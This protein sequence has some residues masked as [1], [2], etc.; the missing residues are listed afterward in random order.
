MISIYVSDS[1]AFS[2]EECLFGSAASHGFWRGFGF[3]GFCG[4]WHVLARLPLSQLLVFAAGFCFFG[5]FSG[6][7]FL[8]GFAALVSNLSY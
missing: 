3:C 7:C 8:L 2:T 1:H 5:P 4:L 6:S